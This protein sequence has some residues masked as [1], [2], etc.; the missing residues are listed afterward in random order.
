MSNLL[1]TDPIALQAFMSET[2]FATADAVEAFSGQSE[3]VSLSLNPQQVTAHQESG[4]KRG[5]KK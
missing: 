1:T 4:K 5:K 3:S 2:I